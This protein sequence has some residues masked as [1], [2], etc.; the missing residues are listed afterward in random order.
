MNDI[1]KIG[2]SILMPI[3]NG[4]E[5]IHQSVGSIF[6]QTYT[7]WELIIGINGHQEN[8]EIY[9][10]AK[11]YGELFNVKDKVKII[12]FHNISGKSNTLNKM[13]YYCS[14]NWVSLLDVDDIWMPNKLEL[15]IAY[16]KN[17]D[18][19]GTQCKY[20]GDLHNQPNIP[21]GD[22]TNFDFKKCNPIINS[23]CLLRKELCYW[24]NNYDGVE[25][26]ELWLKLRKEKY[27]FYNV[28]ST[29]VLHRIHNTSSFNSKGNNLLVRNLLKKYNNI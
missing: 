8:S 14:Y 7:N 13:L 9:K 6:S 26:Y 10:I 28:N 1:N 11:E 17:Y 15:Q 3:Y 20:F 25:D 19:I 24:D 2:I 16:T 21:V 5:F 29:L 23:S 22:I 27:K 12:D 4:I 18:I